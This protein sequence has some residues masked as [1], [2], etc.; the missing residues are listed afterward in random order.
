[1]KTLKEELI[2]NDIIE[3]LN[4]AESKHPKWPSD[5]IH[6]VSIMQEESGESIRAAIQLIYEDGSLNDLKKELKQTAAMCIRV[7]KNL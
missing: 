7:L 4:K 1:M 3:E 2:I 5:V 6:A